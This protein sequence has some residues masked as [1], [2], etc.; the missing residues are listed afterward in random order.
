MENPPNTPRPGRQPRQNWPVTLYSH[1]EFTWSGFIFCLCNLLG[2]QLKQGRGIEFK[3]DLYSS[4]QLIFDKSAKTIWHV[5]SIVEEH[6]FQQMV[7]EQLDINMQKN[8][9]IPTSCHIQKL[10]Q[11]GLQTDT[12]INLHDLRAGNCFLVMTPRVQATTNTKKI[13]WSTAKLKTFVVQRTPSRKGK[14]SSQNGRKRL[15][16]YI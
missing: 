5:L 13:V 1:G 2:L 16:S 6:S 4:D 3:K 15:W 11:N 7:Q 8:N 12:D 10:T 14:N 9:W